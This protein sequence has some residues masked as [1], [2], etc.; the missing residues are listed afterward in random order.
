MAAQ[1]GCV[2]VNVEK[3]PL[4][5]H[6]YF[7]QVSGF[8]K[9]LYY[10]MR[11]FLGYSQSQLEGGLIVWRVDEHVVDEKWWFNTVNNTED[12]YGVMP[13]FYADDPAVLPEL[14]GEEISAF[15]KEGMTPATL[16][17]SSETTTVRAIKNENLRSAGDGGVLLAEVKGLS[18]S[19]PTPVPELP[20]TGDSAQPVLWLIICM[21][22]GMS[23]L[24]L[25]RRN[26]QY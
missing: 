10:H 18:K 1:G 11:R 20:R 3:Y 19:T 13:L 6:I 15:L 23:L 25:W 8:D 22:S 2:V 24:L 9:G 12:E 21:L 7:I 17:D 5:R 16:V 26:R 14:I 4:I